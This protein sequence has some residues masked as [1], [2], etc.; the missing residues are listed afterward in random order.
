MQSWRE[1]AAWFVALVANVGMMLLAPVGLAFFAT[2]AVAAAWCIRIDLGERV[3]QEVEL[4][5]SDDP[6]QNLYPTHGSVNR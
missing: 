5:D 2:L 4:P 3:V 6:V 1:T